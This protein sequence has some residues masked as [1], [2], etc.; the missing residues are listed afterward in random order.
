MIKAAVAGASGYAGGETL[1]LLAQHPEIDIVTVTAASSS[2]QPLGNYQPHI[3][4][5]AD[6]MIQETRVDTLAGHDL[7]ILALPHGHSGAIGDALAESG[8]NGIVVDLAADHRLVDADEWARYY[9][10][11]YCPAWTYAMP[12]LLH[13]GESRAVKQRALI[14]NSTRLAV[15][16]C[17]ATA[18][19]LA[20]QC[21]VN[22]N[23]IDTQSLVATL[24]VGYSGAGKTLKPHLLA[25]Q[26]SGTLAPYAVGGSHRHIP[27][28]LQN[29]R[30]A[31]ATGDA[32]LTFTPVLAP[33][34]RGILA[35]VVA[36]LKC[37]ITRADV[38]QALAVYDEEY[39]VTVTQAPTWPTTGPLTGTGA[40]QI[41]WSI[42]ERAGALVMIC[43]IDNLG[44]GTA[45]AALQS[46]NIALGLPEYTAVPTIG[47]AP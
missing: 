22:A 21:A 39:L 20:A 9:G 11:E 14:A 36:P 15:P 42:D 32:R 40:V 4:Q 35:T 41:H 37:G 8:D 17:N 29:L 47:V 45:A 25:S 46:A 44:K 34:S 23:I 6:R 5:L 1:R 18:V 10:G 28:I 33:L 16:G 24:A 13:A 12:E 38:D 26:A 27:E 31:G 43:A 3:P 2:G 7:V 19:T 30:L